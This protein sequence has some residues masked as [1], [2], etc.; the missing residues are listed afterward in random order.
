MVNLRSH[1][2]QTRSVRA[3]SKTSMLGLM[4]LMRVGVSQYG[5]DLMTNCG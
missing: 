1:R 5:H 4:K 2:D 3:A